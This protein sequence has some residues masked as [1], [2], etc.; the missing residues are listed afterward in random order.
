MDELAEF[1]AE[2]EPPRGD[3]SLLKCS[4]KSKLRQFSYRSRLQIDSNTERSRV[5]YGLINANRYSGL[6]QAERKAQ[7][8]DAASCD[9]DVKSLHLAA[10]RGSLTLLKVSNSI[11][12]SSP[13][14]FST[15]RI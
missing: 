13:S 9:N 3:T 2:V 14:A 12:R 5:A 1:V 15:L 10:T 4:A 7:P 11:L 8:A 6:M